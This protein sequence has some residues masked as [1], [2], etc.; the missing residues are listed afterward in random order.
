MQQFAK[1]FKSLIVIQTYLLSQAVSYSYTLGIH[2][3]DLDPG[4]ETGVA[5]EVD[6]PGE[7]PTPDL[8]VEI[9]GTDQ[10]VLVG[11]DQCHHTTAGLRL[12]RVLLDVVGRHLQIVAAPRGLTVQDETQGHVQGHDCERQRAVTNGRWLDSLFSAASYYAADKVTSYM[13]TLYINI[14]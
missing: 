13:I 4:E 7:L 10:E 3:L 12:Q 1:H 8:E 5:R 11:N 14:Y 9:D 2:A 6:H